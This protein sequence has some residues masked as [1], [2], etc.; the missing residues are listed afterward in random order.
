MENNTFPPRVRPA[1]R[2]DIA[3]IVKIHLAAFHRGFNLSA[4]G[5][6]FLRKY[7]ELILCFEH[8]ILLVAQCGG[9]LE[10]FAAGFVNP[11]DFYA[12]LKQNKWRLAFAAM[13]AIPTCPSVAIRL[14]EVARRGSQFMGRPET[15]NTNY[16]ELSSIAVRPAAAKRGLGKALIEAFLARASEMQAAKVYLTTDANNNDAVNAFYRR[17]NFALTEAFTTPSGRIL[18]EYAMPLKNSAEDVPD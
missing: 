11:K 8:S 3:A 6:R 4:F 13:T 12:R 14:F 15:Q 5:P 7:Y 2:D 1:S 17:L 18:N 9:E 10:G 16:C